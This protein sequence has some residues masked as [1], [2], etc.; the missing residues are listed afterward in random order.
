MGK[1]SEARNGAGQTVARRS[2]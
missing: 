1:H 2:G